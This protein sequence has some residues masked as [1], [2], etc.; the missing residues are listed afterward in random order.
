MSIQ[1]SIEILNNLPANEF[2]DEITK[3]CGSSAWVNA[4]LL[5]RPFANK[6]QLLNL[7]DSIWENLTEKDYLEAFT[8]HPQIGDIDSLRKKFASTAEWAGNEQKGTREASIEILKS[9]KMANEE[10]LNK[11]GFIF[12]VCATGKTAKQILD[13]I[14]RRMPNNRETE[15]QIAA[16]EQ[17]KITGLRLYKLLTHFIK[18]HVQH[19][20][21]KRSKNNVSDITTHV[22]DTAKGCP[23]ANIEASLEFL[24]PDSSWHEV[25]HGQTDKDG[26]IMDWMKNKAQ[27]GQYRITFDTH[28][29]HKG[30]GF[31]PCVVIYFTILDA[32]SHYHVPLLLSPFSYSTY[33]GS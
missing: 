7:S 27:A 14:R 21:K 25:G 31:F 13:L 16:D 32:D 17:N 10:Y 18:K 5:S 30:E 4:L 24:L 1:N 2:V 26:R 33:R 15:L 22:L 9:L 23:A 6:E 20:K 29:Y 12:I 19:E 3:C 11:F 8:H 28:S